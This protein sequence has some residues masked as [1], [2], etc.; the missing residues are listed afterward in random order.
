[1]K[2][3]ILIFMIPAVLSFS[4]CGQK[5]DVPVKIKTAL[6]QKFPQARNVSWD[7]EN[8]TEWEAEFTLNGIKYSAN[9][10][11]N[12]QWKETE[13]KLNE[14]ALPAAV[15]TS[16]KNNFAGY[17]VEGAEVSETPQAMVYELS[18]ILND[19]DIVVLIA[20]DGKV[21]K[22]KVKTE[23]NKDERTE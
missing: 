11:S 10:D 8:A 9:F 3:L 4:A 17:D 18:I 5:E 16:L 12:G 6:T 13:Y 7:K 20:A 14:S 23:K 22:K 15:K 21:I 2:N 1:M 19:E